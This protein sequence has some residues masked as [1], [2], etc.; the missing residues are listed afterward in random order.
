MTYQEVMLLCLYLGKS[1]YFN[2]TGQPLPNEDKYLDTIYANLKKCYDYKRYPHP[3]ES[4]DASGP[5]TITIE[6][7]KFP[8]PIHKIEVTL[9][10]FDMTVSAYAMVNGS[11]VVIPEVFSLEAVMQAKQSFQSI[12][13]NL[14]LRFPPINV[15]P[16]NEE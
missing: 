6:D 2:K 11:L 3:A 9:D 1:S 10:K 12:L 5:L 7:V 16:T 13:D 14:A 8:P 15:D 4:I